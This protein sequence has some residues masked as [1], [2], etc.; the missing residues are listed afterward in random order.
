MIR[1]N[2]LPDNGWL[3]FYSQTGIDFFLRQH[4][5]TQVISQGL[6]VA[7]FGPKTARFAQDQGMRIDFIGT[8]E[9]MTTAKIFLKES[10]L[11]HVC[12]IKGRNSK[13]AMKPLIENFSEISSMD[14]YDNIGKDQ[15]DVPLSDILVF[16]SPLNLETYFTHYP[17]KASQKVVAIGIST[18]MAALQIG[19]EEVHIPDQPSLESLAALTE[20]LCDTWSPCK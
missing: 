13:E 4:P 3:F 18:T 11:S 9:A 14:V 2:G 12:F 5:P 6:K 8:G 15:I 1:S 20:N 10:D 7:T 17:I 19:V 16:T